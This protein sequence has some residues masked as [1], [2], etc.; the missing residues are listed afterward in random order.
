MTENRDDKKGRGRPVK[1]DDPM[2]LKVYVLHLKKFWAH[3]IQDILM[4]QEGIEVCRDTIHRAIQWA[5]ERDRLTDKETLLESVDSCRN[6]IRELNERAD[7]IS[8]NRRMT[9]IWL[10]IVRQIGEEEE[11]LAKLEGNIKT[12]FGM[13]KDTMGALYELMSTTRDEG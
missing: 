13:D 3:E 10:G 12:Y 2:K 1:L 9:H 8:D 7:K 5:R 4:E 11:R 6:R